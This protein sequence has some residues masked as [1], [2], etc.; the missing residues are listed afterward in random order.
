MKHLP[1]LKN[2][3]LDNCWRLKEIPN[4]SKATNLETLSLSS[5][6]SLV[7][8][9]SSIRNLHKLKK[10]NMSYCKR[11][12]VIPTNINL[13]SLEEV[14]MSSCT[15]LRTFPDIS[16]NIK[17]LYVA[18]TKIEDVPPSV[19]GRWSRLNRLQMGSRRIKRLAHVP[20]SVTDLVLS[21][22]DIKR[23]PDCVTGLP[24]L[25]SL[26]IGNCRKLV[27]LQ[28]LPPSLRKLD[29]FDCE[30]LK[31]VCFSFDEPRAHVTLNRCKSEKDARVS[32]SIYH[33]TREVMFVNCLS[34]DEEERRA[35]IQRWDYKCLV[36]PSKQVPAEFTHKGKNNSITISSTTF[37]ASSRFK[38]C[39]LLSLTDQ[40]LVDTS[41]FCRLKSKGVLI[42][43]FRY[44]VGYFQL[45]TEHL[46]VFS[47]DLFEEHRC[48]ESDATTS[49]IIFEFSGSRENFDKNTDYMILGCGVQI[50]A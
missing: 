31:S 26:T 20:L 3:A 15:Q 2:I 39:L 49:D 1:N 48:L 21:K 11:L 7:E 32:S 23:V 43:E 33:P 22:S 25:E 50:L 47:G 14:N 28:S 37:S 9:P 30:S 35:I 6:K 29:V 16:S 5:C 19:V 10:L 4:L 18:N 12:R 42:K 46:I 27:S 38:A 24:C 36:L 34:L 17:Y 8:L 13:A 44:A 41:G 40:A 45:L